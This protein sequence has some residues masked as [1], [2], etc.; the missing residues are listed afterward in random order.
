MRVPG[1]TR[2]LRAAAA[3]NVSFNPEWVSRHLQSETFNSPASGVNFSRVWWVFLPCAASAGSNHPAH[4][5]SGLTEQL[6]AL[7]NQ[8]KWPCLYADLQLD[9]SVL[10]PSS[11]FCWHHIVGPTHQSD[12]ASP[13]LPSAELVIFM[14]PTRLSIHLSLI[15]SWCCSA[16][17]REDSFT[18]RYI[19]HLK[20]D[21]VHTK[22]CCHIMVFLLDLKYVKAEKRC[23]PHHFRLD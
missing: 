4:M 19:T 7:S 3:R 20:L 8:V 22:R 21:T 10:R 12:G 1:M 11:P 17:V 15:D 18:Q 9:T 13:S 5:L 2:E 23:A 16:K 14:S 6:L